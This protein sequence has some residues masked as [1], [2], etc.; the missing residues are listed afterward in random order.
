MA[1]LLG[2]KELPDGFAYPAEFLRVV[3]LGLVNLEPWSILEGDAL[4][5]R[6]IGLLRRYPARRLVPSA[7]R[8]DNDDIACWERSHGQIV[9]I[10]DFASP[11][12]EN[13][14]EFP[15]FWSWFRTAI[16]DFIAFE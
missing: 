14:H 7:R 1:E 16:E 10:H 3:D 6:H 13:R 5:E 8:E 11:G 2:P 9:V 15:D 4:R 12:F